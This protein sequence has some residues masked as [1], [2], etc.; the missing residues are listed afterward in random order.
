MVLIGDN[1]KLNLN[2][3]A[4][5]TGAERPLRR[6]GLLHVGTQATSCG[7]AT[8]SRNR[9]VIG[10]IIGAANYDIGHIALGNPGGGVASLGVVGGNSK[11]QGC[12]GLH[13]AG[14]RLLRRRLRGARDGPPVRRQP[15]LQRHAGQLLGR[16][17]QRGALRSSRARA[18]R[19]WPTPA[20]A[21]RTTCSR[22]PTRTGRSA[23]TTRSRRWSPARAPISEVQTISLRD[24]DGTDSLTL[25]FKRQRRSGRSCAASNYTAADIQGALP[26]QE[27]QTVQLAGYDADGDSYTLN[28]KGA[29]TVPIVRG[30]NNTAAGIAN[31]IAGGNEQ[32]QVTLASFN[33]ATQ[34][35]QISIG[36]NTSVVL[37]RAALAVTQR[38]RADGDQRHRGLRGRRDGGQRRQ[39]RLHRDVRGRLGGRRR[40]GDLDRQLHRHL[41]LDR[42]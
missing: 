5:M 10:Q 41:H 8:L 14:R 24:F 35:F 12:T 38:Q 2:T 32:Q 26:G 15:H 11:A 34:S 6:R 20:S 18:R 25:T 22:T 42:A 23:A 40:P 7:G 30:Q 13:D 39:Q 17:P 36:G 28:Y 9:I 27:V 16:Q 3:A 21:S 4:Q 33:G 31:A 1:D 29:D 37:G 19:S